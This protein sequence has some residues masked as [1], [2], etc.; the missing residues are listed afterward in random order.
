MVS[1]TLLD[2]LAQRLAEV[3]RR[4]FSIFCLYLELLLA[5]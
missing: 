1:I 5:S 4:D 3:A 2:E